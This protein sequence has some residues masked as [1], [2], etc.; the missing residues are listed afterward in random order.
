MS[1]YPHGWAQRPEATIE[2]ATAYSYGL[3]SFELYSYGLKHRQKGY[4]VTMSDA[5]AALSMI[6]AVATRLVAQPLVVVVVMAVAGM[7]V[8]VGR[9]ASSDL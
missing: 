7:G 2:Q 8:G 6:A 9:L 1:E 4:R 3:Y 5:T